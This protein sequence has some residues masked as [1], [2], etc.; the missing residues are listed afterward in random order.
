MIGEIM[1]E[2]ELRYFKAKVRWCDFDQIN[3]EKGKEGKLPNGTLVLKVLWTLNAEK[4]KETKEW[5]KFDD[6]E[7]LPVMSKMYVLSKSKPE[8]NDKTYKEI[9]EGLLK[10]HFDFDGPLTEARD[11]IT[12]FENV[13]AVEEVNGFENVKYVNNPNKRK[14]II[15]ENKLNDLLKLL[16]E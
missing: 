5:Y 6:S 3:K 9:S 13:L 7:D 16:D 1:P 8:G 15:P 14:S 2:N 11:A 10:D 4:D 12:G